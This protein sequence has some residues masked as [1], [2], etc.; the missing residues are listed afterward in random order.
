Y[1]LAGNH[2]TDSSC[3]HLA[4][5][6]RNNQ[7][8]RIL[9]LS[10]NNLE[11]PHFSD[12]MAALTTS[13][14]EELC[15]WK[16]QLTDSSCIHLASGIR[17]NQTLRTLNLSENNLEGPHFSDLMAALTTSRIEKL[18]LDNNHLTDSSCLYLAS[19]VRNNQ[20]LRTLDLS[21]NNLEGPHFSD[22]MAALTT[23]QIEEFL[24]GNNHL[25]D[26]SCPHLASLIRNNQTLRKLNL[27]MNNLE[28]PHFSDLM[29]ALTTSRIEKLHLWK[30][31]LT[32]SSCPHLA[33][34]IRNNQTLRTLDL[35]GNN[36][37]GPHFSDLMAAL[38]TSR[39]E[40]LELGDNQLTD[41][42]CPHLASLIRNNQTLRTL[43]L[44]WNNLEGPH[45]SDLMAA[46]TTSRI[47]ELDLHITHLTDSSCPHL[48]SGIRNNQTLRTLNLS[49]NNLEGP[50]FGDLMAALTTSRIEELK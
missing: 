48:A 39:I 43:N 36:L 14:I 49:G 47:E 28:G 5:G 42:S 21:I 29:A 6:I 13:Q 15:L 27:S 24:L 45:F 1:S 10:N 19:G 35:S 50:H 8:L 33:S 20:T 23:S 16:S 30:S 12:M 17:N 41:S 3:P 32:D 31:H 9:D 40:E 34:G 18:L 26:S 4:S 46:L 7:T 22:L 37:E 44:S 25:T 11:G 2:L 38:T